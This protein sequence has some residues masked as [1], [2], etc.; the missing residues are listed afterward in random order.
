MPAPT[1]TPLPTPPSRSTDPTNFATEADAFV[2]ALPEFVTDANA[3]AA[4][5]DGVASAVDADA[6]AAAASAT[7]AANSAN[8][9]ASVADYQGAYNA[10]TTYQIGQSVSYNGD[11]YVANTVNT[12]VT[13]VSGANWYLIANGDVTLNGNQ[14]LTNKTIAFAS[15][16]LTDVMSLNTAQ[17][18][19]ATK[20]FNGTSSA[21]AAVLANAAEPCTI[22]ATAATGTMNYDISTQSVLYY[23]SN[24]SADWTPNFR[25][26][27]GTSLDTAMTTGQAITVV[28]L[29]T[30]GATAY[31]STAVQVDG[32]AV[33]PKWQ[34]GTA[35][36]GGNA[37][38]I[39]IYTYTIVKTGSAA[40]TVF[41]SQTQFK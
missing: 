6:A 19:T 11:L 37:S 20:T 10:G 3:Q 28:F 9:A 38:S 36:S 18:V 21:I 24:A 15:N 35:P 40:F 14:V 16:T 29:V 41:A 26:S 1:I 34:G 17:T 23:T 27:S 4:Y 5:L 39:D 2:A 8:V 22:S 25:F 13:P 12:G 30:Q 33:T 7:A 32:N 31:K